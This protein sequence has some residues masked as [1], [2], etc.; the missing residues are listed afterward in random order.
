MTRETV[1]ETYGKPIDQTQEFWFDVA[2]IEWERLGKPRTPSGYTYRIFR[3]E[4]ARKYL[5]GAP[6]LRPN[7]EGPQTQMD[8]AKV[9]CL[10]VLFHETR[11]CYGR[12]K[13]AF[14]HFYNPELCFIQGLT[15]RFRRNPPKVPIA[16]AMMVQH[17]RIKGEHRAA[18]QIVCP[19]LEANPAYVE[20]FFAQRGLVIG[21]VPHTKYPASA[22]FPHCRAGNA[23]S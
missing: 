14:I 18:A 2:E 13:L 8:P 19:V 21:P 5:A 1:T 11:A 17:L 10:G 3:G 22:A 12:R 7:V 4:V 9:E 6:S 23:V 15:N 20:Q 16:L